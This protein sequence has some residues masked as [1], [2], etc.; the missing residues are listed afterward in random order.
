[1]PGAKRA[2]REGVPEAGRGGTQGCRE[3]E[4]GVEAPGPGQS[5]GKELVFIS[6]FFTGSWEGQTTKLNRRTV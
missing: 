5:A 4:R 2:T 3:A 6:F 1:M